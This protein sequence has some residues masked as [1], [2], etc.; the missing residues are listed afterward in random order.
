M[1]FVYLSSLIVPSLYFSRFRVVVMGFVVSGTGA[2][3]VLF[4]L[5]HNLVQWQQMYSM[6]AMVSLVAALACLTFKPIKPYRI[7][8]TPSFPPQRVQS[9]SS[10]GSDTEDEDGEVPMFT[11]DNKVSRYAY[12]VPSWLASASRALL[13][14]S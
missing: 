9:R 7:A 5:V 6:L 12:I 8:T 4:S 1:C 10:F 13:M 3:T 14:E 2:G 11:E